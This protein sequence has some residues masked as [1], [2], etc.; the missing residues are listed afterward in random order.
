M[1]VLNNIRKRSVFLIA[2][3]ALALFAFVVSDVIRNGGFSTNKAQETVA[4]ING[5]DVSRLD[6]SK[7]VDAYERQVGPNISSSQAMTTIWNQEV[8]STLLKQ[9]YESL[10]LTVSEDQLMDNFSTNLANNPTFQ[11]ESGLFSE[12]R[13]QEY[14]SSIKANPQQYEQWLDYVNSTKRNILETTYLNM[15]K[16]GLV[17]TLAE[18]EQEYRFENDKV[19]I[20]YVYVP[21]SSVPDADVAVT[22]AEIKDYITKH[23]KEY[24][25]DAQ[26][27]IQYVSFSEAPSPDDID[28]AR[29]E[30]NSLLTD[31]ND[32]GE[33]VKGFTTTEDVSDFINKYSDDDYAGNWMYEKDVPAAIKDTIFKM[34]VG[35]TYGAY[36]VDNTY[37]VSKLVAARQ[38][39]DSVKSRHILIPIGFNKT[40]SITRTD[41]QAKQTADSVLRVVRANKSKFPDLVNSMSS[42]DFSHKD[43]GRYDW[44]PYQ[45]MVQ[46]FRDFTFE[47]NVGDMEVVKTN[48]G[49]H[50]IE[51][52]GQKNVQPVVKVA[53]LVKDIEASE[54]TLNE[55]FSQAANFE[56]AAREGDIEAVAKD[57]NLSLKPV[58][59]IGELDE[60][61]PG[62]GANR[63]IV[64]WAYNEETSIGDVSKFKVNDGYVI[65]QLTRRAKKGLMS[66]SEASATISPIL[67]KQKKAEQIKASVS[68]TTLQEVA[69]SKGVS[70][71]SATAI[72]MA[73]PTIPG[74]GAEPK[75]IGAAFGV[76]TNGE[77]GLIEGNNGVFKVRVLSVNAAPELDNYSSFANQLNSKI[78]PQ[79]NNKV[80]TALK[81]AADIEDNR[82]SI[83]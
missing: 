49:Y 10:G 77:T 72:T 52:E 69:T 48:F 28:N 46:E 82:A 25:V 51:I 65:A 75:V 63:S 2:I 47:G 1:A 68:G 9:Q 27:D 29:E 35:A 21:Y 55:V 78:V 22:D 54:E 70:V 71:Q 3:I 39:P 41:E 15:V 5:E 53:T 76:G 45:A 23:P 42:D 56:V 34:P 19:N 59:K 38:L 73:A 37:N 61:I 66:P 79:I 30:I 8:R 4:T 50:I 60:N 14:I 31:F 58:N 18:G 11:D 44:Y 81:N 57:Q 67:R 16:G 7:K 80:N 64:T 20:E 43:G 40:D 33:T 83:Y 24:E 26:V 74:A 32:N 12:A 17:S 36:K 62:I 13:L 6:F